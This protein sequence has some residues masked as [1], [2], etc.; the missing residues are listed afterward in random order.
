MDYDVALVRI[1]PESSPANRA[2]DI[3]SEASR[4][5]GK[6]DRFG[7]RLPQ[8]F[9][10]AGV[11]FPDGTDYSSQFEPIAQIAPML[12]TLLKSLHATICRTDT[13]REPELAA[14]DAMLI[15]EARVLG[16]YGLWPGMAAAWKRKPAH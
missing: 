9:Q 13:A 4:R 16:T 11:G 7:S 10:D 6:D 3:I 15:A 8:L 1:F 14:L 2:I 5:T 12:R